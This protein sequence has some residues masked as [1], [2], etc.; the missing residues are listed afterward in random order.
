MG[1]GGEKGAHVVAKEQVVE[2]L[3]KAVEE[4]DDDEILSDRLE[5]MNIAPG[6]YWDDKPEPHA[7]R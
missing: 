1:K 3:P 5:K 7:L 2:S 6:F 4:Q